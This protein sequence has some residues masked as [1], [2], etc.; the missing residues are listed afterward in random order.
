MMSHDGPVPVDLV[1][2]GTHDARTTQ[3]DQDPSNGHVERR[4]VCVRSR[5]KGIKLAKAQARKDQTEEVCGIEENE[6]M[7]GRVAEE[8]MEERREARKASWAANL[9]G[10][11]AK[12]KNPMETKS[13]V[14]V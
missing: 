14:K 12:T 11:V 4:C 5:G 8:T 7:K 10:A 3:C 13:K 1:H 6:L 9:I 2:V